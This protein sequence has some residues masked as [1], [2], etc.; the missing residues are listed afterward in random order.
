MLRARRSHRAAV[1]RR[2]QKRLESEDSVEASQLCSA[3]A[4]ELPMLPPRDLDSLHSFSSLQEMP[5]GL[6]GQASL[7]LPGQLS[8]FYAFVAERSSPSI[9]CNMLRKDRLA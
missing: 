7:A 6:S 5:Q 2:L 1:L 4:Y 8:L 3:N 9:P